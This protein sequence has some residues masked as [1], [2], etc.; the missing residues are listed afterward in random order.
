MRP[1]FEQ[2]LKSGLYHKESIP[3]SNERDAMN[4]YCTKLNM[5]VT[6]LGVG[7]KVYL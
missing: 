3:H 4:F 5:I 6:V 1:E 2:I 7:K